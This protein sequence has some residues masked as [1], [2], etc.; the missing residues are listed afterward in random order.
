VN[1][2][3]YQWRNPIEIQWLKADGG[4]HLVISLYNPIVSVIDDDRS[5][6]LSGFLEGFAECAI[7]D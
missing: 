3:Y 1:H 7:D 6:S 2:P 4:C 5:N